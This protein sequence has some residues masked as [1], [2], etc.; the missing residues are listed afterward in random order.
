MLKRLDASTAK[1]KFQQKIL[2][3]FP[4]FSPI[5]FDFP[6]GFILEENQK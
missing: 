4:V 1:G 2:K 5:P 6:I 3:P